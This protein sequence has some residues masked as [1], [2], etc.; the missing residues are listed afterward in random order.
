V[1]ERAR[2]PAK[3]GMDWV[4]VPAGSGSGVKEAI[5]KNKPW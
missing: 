4:A 2:S 3:E 5:L 1:E